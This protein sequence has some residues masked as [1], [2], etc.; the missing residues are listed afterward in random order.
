MTGMTTTRLPADSQTEIDIAMDRYAEGR[1]SAFLTLYSSL[2]PR[3]RRYLARFVPAHA[4]DDLVQE[5]M[6]HLHA[7]RRRFRRGSPAWPWVRTIARHKLVDTHR[8]NRNGHDG[9]GTIAEAGTDPGATPDSLAG[10]LGD[11][12]QLRSA[13]S[14]LPPMQR[15]V[16]ELLLAEST[17]AEIATA[18]EISENAA[19]LRAHRACRAL[20]DHI[21]VQE[22]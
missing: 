14:A 16:C 21:G 18:L 8:R 13:I 3:L 17:V 7:A 10:L 5:T 19:R 15:E 6:A 1:D 11:A 2:A 4:V 12:R 9:T 22:P 20:R